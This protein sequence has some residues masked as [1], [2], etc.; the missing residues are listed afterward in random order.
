M[1]ERSPCA[2]GAVR[3][4]LLSRGCTEHRIKH[5]TAKQSEKLRQLAREIQ[6]LAKD[7]DAENIKALL[8]HLA[9]ECERLA[10]QL[11]QAPC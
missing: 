1:I 7:A 8:N 3:F 4:R 5:M 9:R 2:T 6:E 10:E 11:A